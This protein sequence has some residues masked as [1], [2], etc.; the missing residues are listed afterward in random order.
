MELVLLLSDSSALAIGIDG[1]TPKCHNPMTHRNTEYMGHTLTATYCDTDVWMGP[2]GDIK[3]DVTRQ[4]FQW[5]QPDRYRVCM[6][7]CIAACFL[8]EMFKK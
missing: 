2:H 4:R 5:G 7:M 3:V 1:F 8:A 6:L